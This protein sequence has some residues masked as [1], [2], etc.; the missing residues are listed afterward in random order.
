[1]TSLRRPRVVAAVLA[2][3]A[4]VAAC[5]SPGT[6]AT[7]AESDARLA[8]K[9]DQVLRRGQSNPAKYT[10]RVI[11]PSTGRQLYAVDVDTPF[12]PASN[13]KLAVAAAALDFFGSDHTFKTY[14]ALDG[15]D[16]WIIGTGDPGTGDNP[17]AKQYGGTTMTMLDEWAAALK[18]HGATKLS[19]NLYYYDGELDDELVH[20]S[21]SKGYITEWYAAPIAGLNFNNNCVDISVKPTKEDQPVEYASKIGR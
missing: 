5:Q 18:R 17:I 20:P 12:I 8:A 3:S 2:I 11:D 6:P 21:W 13:G 7:R 1:M 9:L 16:L 19:G 4:L 15:Q 14:L 10:A